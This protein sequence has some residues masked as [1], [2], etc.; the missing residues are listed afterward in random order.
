[1]NNAITHI[2]TSSH[3]SLARFF[4]RCGRGG[5][6]VKDLGDLLD[7]RLAVFHVHHQRVHRRKMFLRNVTLH[8]VHDRLHDPAFA[9]RL[10]GVHLLAIHHGGGLRRPTG[11]NVRL[12]LLDELLPRLLPLLARIGAGGLVGLVRIGFL[13]EGRIEL[14]DFGLI[15]PL[16]LALQLQDIHVPKYDGRASRGEEV[17]NDATPV[18]G[19]LGVVVEHVWIF[20]GELQ[21]EKPTKGDCD[22]RISVPH[23]LCLFGGIEHFDFVEKSS[24]PAVDEQG[25]LILDAQFLV[26]DEGEHAVKR[27]AGSGIDNPAL[28]IVLH[29]TT[30]PKTA[31]WKVFVADLL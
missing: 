18:I 16:L 22:L 12:F 7:G 3:T 20:D 13:P 4:G 25:V 10:C 27:L 24:V 6:A 1:M 14:A 9:V 5:D 11:G 30:A 2:A 26:N 21:V 29:A 31:P 23:V 28:G 19:V 15:R 8:D 17:L